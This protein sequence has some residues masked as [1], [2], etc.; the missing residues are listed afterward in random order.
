VRFRQVVVRGV[1]SPVA[2]AGDSDTAEAVVLLHGNPGSA[3]DWDFA[4]PSIA[5]LARVLAPDMPG[6]G[7]AERPRALPYTVEGY[8]DHLAGILDQLGVRRV[9]LVLHDF[10]GPWGLAWGIEHPDAFASLTLINT[11]VFSG[12][13]WHRFAKV[14]RTPIVGELFQ[15]ATTRAGLRMFLNRANPKPLPDEFIDRIYEDSD[16]GMK[17]AVLKLYRATDIGELAGRQ[18]PALRALGRPTLVIWGVHDTYLPFELADRQHETFPEAEI[19]PIA[20]AG[21]WPFVD[22]PDAVRGPLLRFLREQIGVPATNAG[23]LGS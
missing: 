22:D 3:R 4:I 12:V 21:H 6:F 2:E 11:G 20:G 18:S 5:E 1:R 8:S 13:R 15:A 19:V 7:A 14:W 23:P 17:R 16:P 10:G 9:H